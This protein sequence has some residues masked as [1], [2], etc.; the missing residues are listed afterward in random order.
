MRYINDM[1]RLLDTA[2]PN[3]GKIRFE[4]GAIPKPKEPAATNW[5]H[6]NIGGDILV[7]AENNPDGVA[8]P[9]L[10]WRGGLVDIKHPIGTLNSLDKLIQDG[11]RQTQRNGV[12]VDVSELSQTDE[13]IISTIINRVRRSRGNYAIVIR[14]GSLIAYISK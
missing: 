7:L 5:L 13:Q 1:D 8:N 11:M 2:T 9:D 6:N 4:E 12:L 3:S 14:D 10:L